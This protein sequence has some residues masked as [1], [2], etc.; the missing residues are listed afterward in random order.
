MAKNFIRDKQEKGK[1]PSIVDF[2][3]TNLM[4]NVV[5]YPDFIAYDW[6]DADYFALKLCRL[7]GAPT[8]TWTLKDPAHYEQVQ[9]QFDLY[10]FEGFAMQ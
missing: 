2:L 7:M 8:S 5:G 1:D 6:Q 9:G 4:L 3:T 10:T